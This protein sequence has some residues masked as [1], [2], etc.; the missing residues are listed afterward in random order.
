MRRQMRR[1]REKDLSGRAA[2]GD[3]LTG[4][5]AFV[6]APLPPVPPVQI[7]GELAGEL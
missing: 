4:Y 5:R 6:P 1:P 2:T 3:Q 7:A